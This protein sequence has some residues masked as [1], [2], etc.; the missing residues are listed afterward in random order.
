[1]TLP[2][3]IQ[4]LTDLE[5]ADVHE[6]KRTFS[7]RTDFKKKK[8]RLLRDLMV[9]TGMT[10]TEFHTPWTKVYHEIDSEII[11]KILKPKPN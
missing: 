1:M 10:K 8:F 6:A 2:E 9:I 5:L 3:K 11:K 4:S 7:D